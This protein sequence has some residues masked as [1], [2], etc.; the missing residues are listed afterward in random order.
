ML[1]FRNIDADQAGDIACLV[2][3]AN[4]TSIRHLFQQFDNE[5]VSQNRL[6]LDLPRMQ[7]MLRRSLARG[8]LVQ[9]IVW[10]ERVV[11]QISLQI[12]PECLYQPLLGTAWFGIVIG[13]V[14]ARGH[15]LGRRAMLHLERLARDQ[16]ARAAQVGVFE[17]NQPARSLYKSL[18]YKELTRTKEVTWWKGKRWTDIRMGKRLQ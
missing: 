16:G 14:D 11:G 8:K 9:L 5:A 1:S 12:D 4:D 3:W 6:S 2:R 7:T 17:F 18:Q 13:E 10:Q 15:G